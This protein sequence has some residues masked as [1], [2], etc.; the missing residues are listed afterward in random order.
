[1]RARARLHLFLGVAALL[2]AGGLAA[3][4]FVVSEGGRVMVSWLFVAVGM[5][6]VVHGLSLLPA[7]GGTVTRVG[8]LPAFHALAALLQIGAVAATLVLWAPLVAWLAT[9]GAPAAPLGGYAAFTGLALFASVAALRRGVRLQPGAHGRGRIIASAGIHLVTLVLVHAPLLLLALGAMESV[10]DGF[11]FTYQL[12][13]SLLSLSDRLNEV[14]QATAVIAG[15][16]LA[17]DLIALTSLWFLLPL[18]GRFVFWIVFDILA[19][20][21]FFW[22][23]FAL[24]MQPATDALEDLIDPGT[25]LGFTAVFATRVFVRLLPVFMM[26]I[27]TAGFRPLVA[28]R[29][30]RAKKSGFLAAIGGLSIGAVAVSTCMLVGV[31]S[32]MGGF[33][34]DLKQKIL[35]NHAHVVVDREGGTFEG[36]D[37]TLSAVRG[38]E[39]VVA[40]TPYVEG[41]VMITSATNMSTAVLR[42]VDPASIGAVTDLEQNLTRGELDYLVHPERLLDIPAEQRRTILPLEVR[43]GEDA[44]GDGSLVREIERELQAPANEPDDAPANELDDFLR[45]PPAP[46]DD[47]R[48]VLPG[49]I[50]G[51]ELARTL[52][53]FL[54]D[55]VD[56]VSPLGELGPAGPMPKSRRFRVAGVFYSGMY[57]YDMKLVY[58]QLERAQ[59]FLSTGGAISGIEVKVGDVARA[60]EIAG[61]VRE[62]IGRD[63]LRVRDWQELNQGLFGALEL[64]KLAMFITL[65]IAILIA[66]FC[67]FG[68]LTLMVQEKSR[69]VGI[70]F[71]MGTTRRAVVQIFMLE[72]LLIGLYGAAI[73]LGLGYLVTFVF[74]HFGFRLNPEVYYIDRLP[75]HVDPT[76]FVLVGAV[77]LGICVVATIFP[78]VLASR[79]RPV[80]ALRWQ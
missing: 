38:A 40:A 19:T 79:T 9:G 29:H 18:R 16:A 7:R 35:G 21:A 36:W 41:D 51:K 23:L 47:D 58:V 77:A 75:V 73:G 53:V 74:E 8:P 68:T 3:L 78:A 60:P 4:S 71:A 49:I 24:P 12:D 61:H 65:G 22:S 14:F 76:E 59:A 72:G 32:V 62:A 64:E 46:V 56:V 67:V 11:A 25:R 66:G 1:M 13:E 80:D 2:L 69:E 31:L 10:T 63:S 34:Q 57:E 17:I 6:E 55:E 45:A 30:L 39:G 28:A 43:P 70:L 54:G 27:E 52:R 5:L 42:G 26:G 15:V 50:L 44:D 48:E 20:L 37:P 33:R